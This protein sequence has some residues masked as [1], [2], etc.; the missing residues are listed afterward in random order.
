M[1][2]SE[3]ERLSKAEIEWTRRAE[4]AL[5]RL[6]AF[7]PKPPFG[8]AAANELRGFEHAIEA[9]RAALETTRL[10]RIAHR[11]THALTIM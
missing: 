8:E 2:C 4:I 1:A 7:S 10:Q 11:E 3:C 6:K 9:C 5:A